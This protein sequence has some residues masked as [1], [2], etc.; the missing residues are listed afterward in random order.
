M[1]YSVIRTATDA[2]GPAIGALIK[3]IYADY[4]NCLYVE[5]ELPELENVASYYAAQGG[6]MWVA[7]QNG[8]I[9]G[10]LAIGE[11]LAPGTFELF[12]V[13]VA[14]SARGQGLA[15]SMFNLATDLIDSRGG[16]SIKLW[17]DTRFVD[18]HQFY[19]KIGFSRVPVTRFLADASDTWE[20]C[21]RLDAKPAPANS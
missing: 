21:Y 6:Q 11:S 20:Y 2:D 17:T 18:G 5:A 8:E 7:E 4:E 19:D 10:S 1:S 3:A 9:V 14:R 12:K 16:T 15:W 13:Y